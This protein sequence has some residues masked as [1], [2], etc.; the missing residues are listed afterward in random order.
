M[1]M[2]LRYVFWSYDFEGSGTDNIYPS[3]PGRKHKHHPWTGSHYAK[4]VTRLLGFE[5]SSTSTT[6][7]PNTNFTLTLASPILGRRFCWC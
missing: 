7:P 2:W 1:A 3:G 4:L 6:N 5:L